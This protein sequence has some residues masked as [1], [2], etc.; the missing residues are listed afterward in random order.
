[1]ESKQFIM[2]LLNY[3]P[4]VLSFLTSFVSHVLSYLTCFVPYVLC[5]PKWSRASF[6]LRVLVLHVPLTLSDLMPH[7][8]HVIRALMLD[9]PPALCDLVLHVLHMLLIFSYVLF[10]F[11]LLVT[12]LF[13]CGSC[14]VPYALL[15]SSFLTCFRCFKPNMLIRISCLITFMSCVSCACGAWAIWVFYRL[16]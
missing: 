14:L 7:V 5:C 6:A 4:H 1:M 15:C 3:V 12:C 8:P 9:V 13:S 10:C 11:T 16:V 2:S